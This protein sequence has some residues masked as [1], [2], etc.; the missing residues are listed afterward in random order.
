[1]IKMIALIFAG[2]L[3]YCPYINRYTERLDK[4]GAGYDVLFWNRGGFALSLP[5]NYC[6]FDYPSDLS[7]NKIKKIRDFLLFR[8]WLKGHIKNKKYTG[9]VLLSTLTGIL[10]S[11]EL[12]KCK[13]KYIYDIRDYSFEGIKPYYEMEKKIIKNSYFTAISSKGF[14]DFLPDHEYIIAH[15]FNRNDIVEGVTFHQK[16]QPIKVVWNGVMRFFDFQKLYID[17]LKNDERFLMVYH[18]DGPELGKYKEY[19]QFNSV[20]NVIFTGAYDNSRKAELLNDA[21]ILN[22]CYGYSENSGNKIKYAVSNRFYDGLIYHIPQ[23]VEPGGYKATVVEQYGVGIASLSDKGFT[24][25]LYQYYTSINRADFDGKCDSALEEV[26]AEDNLFV[27]QIDSFI[28][29]LFND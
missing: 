1:M 23:L 14:K 5:P 3:K 22:N 18:G 26:L 28:R 2:D 27:K 19:C 9:V 4:L 15:N 17:A 7:S 13:K 10:L 6:Y 25:R 20:K 21:G 11:T 8:N 29:L 16:D 12:T 24:D